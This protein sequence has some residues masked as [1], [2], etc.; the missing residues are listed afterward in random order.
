MARTGLFIAG[1]DTGVGKTWITGALARALR[2]RR[3]D[4]GVGKPV[5][6]GSQPGHPDADSY[7][8][9]LVSGVADTEAEICP[10]S[11]PTPLTPWLAAHLAGE[12]L[13]LPELVASLDPLFARHQAVLVEG[14][15]GLGAPLTAEHLGLDLAVTLGLP[16]LLVARPGLGTVNHTLLSLHWARQHGLTVVGV[17][18]N[19]YRGALPPLVGDLAQIGPH[20]PFFSSEATNPFL[21]SHFGQVQ[22]LGRVP[23]LPEPNTPANRALHLAAHMDLP[24]L[25]DVLFPPA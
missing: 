7:Q 11:Y 24:A 16:V 2:D 5:Q 13:R 18:F 17:L 15:G 22:V 20:E 23:W 3:L 25:L 6:S 8:L 1:T 21:V 12:T 14:A 10:R 19:G 4:V 9:R